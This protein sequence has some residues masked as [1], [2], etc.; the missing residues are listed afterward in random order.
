MDFAC[1]KD[2]ICVGNG[3]HLRTFYVHKRPFLHPSQTDSDHANTPSYARK[4]PVKDN[5][6]M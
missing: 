4:K 1:T 3:I 6:R 5:N 2:L